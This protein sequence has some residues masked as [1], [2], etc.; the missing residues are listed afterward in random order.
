[1]HPAVK[2]MVIFR[3]RHVSF[4]PTDFRLSQG[5][6]RCSRLEI[7]PPWLSAFAG[8]GHPIRF[9]ANNFARVGAAGEQSA[10]QGVGDA[11]D[12]GVTSTPPVAQTVV[13]TLSVCPLAA[14]FASV[15][16]ERPDAELPWLVVDRHDRLYTLLTSVVM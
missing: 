13:G 9:Q 7:F 3:R 16:I 2:G 11:L 1:M 14:Y 10:G 12:H 6:Q 5:G 8:F 4:A 15:N